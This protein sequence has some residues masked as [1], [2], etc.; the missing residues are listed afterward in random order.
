[1]NTNKKPLIIFGIG[2]I[3][4][5]VSYYFNRDS[6]YKIIAYAVDD[7]FANQSEYMGVPL[8]KLSDIK[9]Q[10]NPQ[11]HNVFVAVGYQGVNSLRANKYKYFKELGYSF[12]SYKSPYVF[13]EYSIGE[14]TIVMDSAVI[15]P[16]ASFGNNVFVWGGAMVGHHATIQDGCW[17]S[18]GCLIGGSVNLGRSSFVGMGAIV[19]QEVKTGVECMLGAGSLTIRSIG[20]KAVVVKEQTEIHRLNSEQF[21]RMSSCFNVNNY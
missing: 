20:D 4:Q 16:L 10:F 15:Q 13:G 19:G 1:M 8:V 11:V 12:A 7:V 2:K 21:T 14:N 18:G 3:S 5:A 6:D 17:L 9:E